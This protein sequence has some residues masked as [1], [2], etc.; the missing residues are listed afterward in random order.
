MR[1]RKYLTP[2]LYVQAGREADY[3][4]CLWCS[5]FIRSSLGVSGWSSVSLIFCQLYDLCPEI[6]AEENFFWSFGQYCISP[7]Y[8]SVLIQMQN[9]QSSQVGGAMLDFG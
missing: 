2:K 8:V 4:L 5:L 3:K 6:C 1:E 7:L 9:G